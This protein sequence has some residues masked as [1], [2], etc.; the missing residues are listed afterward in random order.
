MAATNITL[1]KIKIN[2]VYNFDTLAPSILGTTYKDMKVKAILSAN[3]AIKYRDIYTLHNNLTTAILG[4]PQDVG[5][6]TYV[7]FEDRD[8]KKTVLAL[9][10]I[11]PFTIT[12]VVTTN[13][14]VELYNTDNLDVSVLRT[15]L[16]ELGYNNFNISTF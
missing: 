14:R 15:R 12:E 5:D 3:E 7:L 16:L 10:Y 13:V 6:C 4:L 8:N 11:D 1:D 2:R 9:E